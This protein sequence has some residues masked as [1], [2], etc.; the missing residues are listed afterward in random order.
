MLG[1]EGAGRAEYV[2]ARRVEGT[3]VTGVSGRRGPV[4]SAAARASATLCAPVA[5]R[6]EG[7][8]TKLPVRRRTPVVSEHRVAGEVLGDGFDAAACGQGTHALLPVAE[9]GGSQVDRPVGV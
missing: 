6:R 2:E 3:P 9:P 4:G 5:K 1:M 7:V 8:S